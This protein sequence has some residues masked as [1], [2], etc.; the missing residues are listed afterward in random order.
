MTLETLRSLNLTSMR[1][2][3]SPS[4]QL[5]RKEHASCVD[6]VLV[7]AK[8]SNFCLKFSNVT[9]PLPENFG[10]AVLMSSWFL[11]NWVSLGCVHCVSSAK[12]ASRAFS[13][14]SSPLFLFNF[15]N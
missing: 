3:A 7:A 10:T 13:A 11:N 2:F 4:K 15:R 1:A 9:T 8:F 14:V 5:M 12:I 6:M